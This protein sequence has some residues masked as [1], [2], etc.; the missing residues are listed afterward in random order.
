MFARVLTW[1]MAL[2]VGLFFGTAGTITYSS[3][4]GGLPVGL[5]VGLVGCLAILVAIR[6][7]SRDRMAVAVTALGMIVAL[8]VFSGVGPGGSVIIPSSPLAMVW[9]IG[10]IAVAV[11]VVMWPDA[12]KLRALNQK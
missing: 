7:I 9:S 4:P 12:S 8:V 10:V 3:M 5:V 6:L 2:A 1:V 11:L